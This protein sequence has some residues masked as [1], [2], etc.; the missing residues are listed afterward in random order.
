MVDADMSWEEEWQ[1]MPEYEQE[2]MNPHRTIKVHFRTQ[3]D[4]DKFSLIFGQK[5]NPKNNSYW[6]PKLIR[7]IASDKR[8]EDES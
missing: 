4:L 8:Y 2:D 7:R 5:I 6:F 1:D 3:N